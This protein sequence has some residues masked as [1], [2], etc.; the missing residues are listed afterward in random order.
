MINNRPADL[1]LHGNSR[2]RTSGTIENGNYSMVNGL[3]N[4]VACSLSKVQLY[5]SMYNINNNNNIITLNSTDITIPIGVY[6][7]QATFA[8]TLQTAITAS[9]A[10]VTV[11]YSSSKNHLVFAGTTVGYTAS[12]STISEVISTRQ[13]V[14]PLTTAFLNLGDTLYV[15]IHSRM[16]TPS[17]SI[18]LLNGHATVLQTIPLSVRTNTLQEYQMFT[19]RDIVKFT[20]PI[21]ITRFDLSL[22]DQDGILLDTNNVNFGFQLKFWTQ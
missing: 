21:E 17:N 14:S 15:N 7:D 1:T 10:G 18:D 9:I 12:T 4:V 6:S 22:R 13:D 2:F 5:N 11:S 19:D 16:L 20:S 8:S 3:H